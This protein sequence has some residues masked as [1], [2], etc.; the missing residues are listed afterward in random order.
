MP[1]LVLF[2]VFVGAPIFELYLLIELG[3]RIGALPTI[4]LTV[5]TA[6]LGGV[7]VRIQGLSVL[8]RVREAF[9]NDEVPAIELIEGA[10][11]LGTGVLLLLP[12]LATDV[13]GF[14]LLISPL[15]RSL[16]IGVLQRRGKLRPTVSR[17]AQ[18]ATNR[19]G[20]IEGEYRRED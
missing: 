11:L 6:I 16:I 5:F 10:V 8:M 20:Y 3:S 17:G 13:L 18:G 1:L 4:A 19:Q 9:A 15:R 14:L 2:L 12:G 7:L